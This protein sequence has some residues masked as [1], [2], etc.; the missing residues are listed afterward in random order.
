MSVFDP[1]LGEDILDDIFG[2]LSGEKELLN[3]GT[4]EPVLDQFLSV[5]EW[6]RVRRRVVEEEELA[7]RGDSSVFL[8]R[9][10]LW[11]PL[12]ESSVTV[13]ALDRIREPHEWA[14]VE[15]PC[16]S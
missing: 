7:V 13:E 12:T 15:E 6:F 3:Q 1:S 11:F 4:G 5:V 14:E 9:I 16:N 8:P 2:A 10:I